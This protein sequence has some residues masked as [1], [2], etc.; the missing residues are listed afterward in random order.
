[1]NFVPIFTSILIVEAVLLLAKCLS[2]VFGGF[3]DLP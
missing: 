1:M 2:E 3:V